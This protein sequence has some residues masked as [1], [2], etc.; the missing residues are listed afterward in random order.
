[1]LFVPTGIGPFPAVVIIH[2]SG[3]SRRQ[4]G[5]YLTLTEYLQ[6]NGIAVLLPDKR[7][8]EKS[9]GNWRNASFSDLA[10]DTLAAI[11]FLKEQDQVAVSR[12]GIV[13]MSQG[14]WIAPI[15][16]NGSSDVAFLVNVVGSAVTPK[17]Q[18]IYEEDHNL[19]QVG[20]LPGI[21][22]LIAYLSTAYIR[23]VAQRDFWSANGNFDPLPLWRQLDIDALCL[24]GAD[25]TNVPTARSAENLR[26]LNNPN[27]EVRI[28]EGSG[29]ALEEPEG[30]GDSI[31]RFDAL[32][33]IARFIHAQ[34]NR[35]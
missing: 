12:I 1:M 30:L 3:T 21:S 2:G 19:R 14:G 9:E 15:V 27:V 29:H 6:K 17:E 7:G 8:S 35:P 22:R 16:A 11:Q 34:P 31:F 32:R 18:L 23:N 4:N 10:T 28:F 33:D 13:G 26:S 5:W 25:D 20:F 24:Y